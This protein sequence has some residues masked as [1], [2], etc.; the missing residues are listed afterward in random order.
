MSENLDLV[1][2]IYA[3]WERGDFTRT[4]WADREIEVV[5]ADGPEPDSRTGVAARTWVEGYVNVWDSLRFEISDYR[6][7]DGGRV[8][9]LFRI[10]ARGKGSGV[11]VDQ[12]RASVF[13]IEG[14]SVTRM[15]TYWDRDR[16][17]ADLGLKE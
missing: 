11:E 16:A 2:S 1:R 9:V 10:R 15:L 13:H 7:L 5:V 4:D 3:D 6:E 12:H 8:L 17:L 14:G